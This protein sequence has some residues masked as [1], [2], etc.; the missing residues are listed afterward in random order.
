L[1]R[2]TH[3]K[4]CPGCGGDDLSRIHR[5]FWMRWLKGSRLFV[6]RHCRTRILLLRQEQSESETQDQD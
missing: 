3:K 5:K 4:V 1:A 2:I 6:C